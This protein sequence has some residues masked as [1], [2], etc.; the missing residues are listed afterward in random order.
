MADVGA[1]LALAGYTAPIY[2]LRYSPNSKYHI[3]GEQV[4]MH[5]P[6][7]KAA[8]KKHLKT[9]CSPDFQPKN[10][11]NVHYMFYDLE[12]EEAGPAIMADADFPE[13]MKDFVTWCT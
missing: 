13:V 2:W 6:E 7:R 5:R 9:L 4:K 8:L 1:S 11:V 10:Q 3:G 12:S